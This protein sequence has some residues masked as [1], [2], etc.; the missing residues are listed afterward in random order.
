M[1]QTFNDAIAI[2]LKTQTELLAQMLSGIWK[3]TEFTTQNSGVT[4]IVQE[5]VA[6]PTGTFR[7]R[8]DVNGV[9]RWTTFK[10]ELAQ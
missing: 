2:V 9:E 8:L 10:K 7:I 3:G 1:E 5:V 6:N 4:G